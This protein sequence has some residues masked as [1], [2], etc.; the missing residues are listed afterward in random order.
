MTTVLPP[1]AMSS[2]RASTAWDDSGSRPDVGSSSSSSSGSCSTARA[3]ARTR[4]HAGRIAA[5]AQVEGVDD[6]KVR[7]AGLDR[8]AR[9]PSR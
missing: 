5:D 8:R 4:L 9:D 6:P 2:M 7:R 1:S 3:R